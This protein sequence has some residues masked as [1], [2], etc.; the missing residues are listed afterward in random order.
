MLYTIENKCTSINFEYVDII[1]KKF[2]FLQSW[3]NFCLIRE[4]DI[5][6]FQ[7]DE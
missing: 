6:I 2:F 1:K 5:N 3:P 4:S 7:N